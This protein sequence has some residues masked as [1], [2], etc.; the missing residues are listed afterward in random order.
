MAADVRVSQLLASAFSSSLDSTVVTYD[1]YEKDACW[2]ALDI[3]QLFDLSHITGYIGDRADD[4]LAGHDSM[5]LYVKTLTGRTVTVQICATASIAELKQ[6]I[7]DAQGVPTDQQR[8]IFGKKQLED[9]RTLCD[10]NIQNEETVHLV[11]RLRGGGFPKYYIN[12]KQASTTISR[13][14]RMMEQ[15]FS[16]EASHTTVHMAGS[17]LH[18]KCLV[19]TTMTGGL[20]RLVFAPDR[21]RGNGPCHTTVQVTM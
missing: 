5:E 3:N 9:G 12:D 17:G 1:Q 2:E 11:L 16:V 7:Q 6:K 18:S 14:R 15:N 8:L 10:Y 19:N 4:T 20:E 13:T 21:R